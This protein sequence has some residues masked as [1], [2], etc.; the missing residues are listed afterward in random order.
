MRPLNRVQPRMPPQAYKS[1]HI[2]RPLASHFRRATCQEA[3]CSAYLRGWHTVIDISRRARG[4]LPSGAAQ[5]NY[6]RLHSGRRYSVT[7]NGDLVT[8]TFAAGQQCFA[9]HRVPVGREPLFVVSD[10]DWRGNPRGTKPI[11]FRDYRAF[12]D[13]FGEHQLRLADRQKKG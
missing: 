4:S 6:I 9:E 13:D 12:L 10:G 8:F 7:Q 3:N 1:Y 5:A 2:A 11:R